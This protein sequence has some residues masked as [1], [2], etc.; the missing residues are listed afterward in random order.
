MGQYGPPNELYGKFVWPCAHILVKFIEENSKIFENK[1]VLEIGSGVN[2]LGSRKVCEFASSVV[3]TDG[4]QDIVSQINDV[5][6]N[7]VVDKLV[8]G[9][10]VVGEF[11]V[12]I[13]SDVYYN[14]VNLKC[15]FKTIKSNLKPD[16]VCYL[17]LEDRSGNKL[18]K[19]DVIKTISTT[20]IDPSLYDE[21]IKSF[22]NYDRY[23]VMI[24]QDDLQEF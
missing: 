14:S 10:T 9:D 4:H 23:I 15:L 3:I 12:I 11:D 17:V 22:I 19:G 2:A 16:G 8:F 6:N 13:G 18:K 1:K 24:K 21:R 7:C 20:E 5:P